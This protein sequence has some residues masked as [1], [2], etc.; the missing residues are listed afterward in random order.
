MVGTE[1]DARNHIQ[2]VLER[3]E[4]DFEVLKKEHQQKIR[5]ILAEIKRTKGLSPM[6]QITFDLLIHSLQHFISGMPFDRRV[7]I[8]HLDQAVELVL[9]E[10]VRLAGRKIIQ[11]ARKE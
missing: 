1:R 2:Q 9:K 4:K 11:P 8:L 10:R 5:K 6:L 7:A 3:F